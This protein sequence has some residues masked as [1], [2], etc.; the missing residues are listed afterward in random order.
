METIIKSI[1]ISDKD[2]FPVPLIILEGSNFPVPTIK[3]FKAY[4]GAG[5]G[6]FNTL[7]PE[8]IFGVK[9]SPACWNHDE[10]WA[11]AEP[12]WADFH[13]SNSIFLS[14]IISLIG[15][16]SRSN[17]MKHLRMYRAVT[18]YNAVDT[19]GAPIFWHMKR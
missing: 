4:C 15:Y 8:Y 14:N 16:Q 10:M 7:V 19:I 18:Y 3:E 2:P 1:P 5:D 12:T 9:I 11:A 17:T 13:Y 6:I